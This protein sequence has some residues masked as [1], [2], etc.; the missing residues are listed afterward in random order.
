M[1]RSKPSYL[2]KAYLA[3]LSILLGGMYLSSGVYA[4]EL[5][6]TV[7][8]APYPLAPEPT[9][10]KK[11]SLETAF[12]RWSIKVVWDRQHKTEDS[13]EARLVTGDVIAGLVNRLAK[14]QRL[15]DAQAQSLYEDRRKKYY[16]DA[17]H[18]GFGDKIVFMGHIELDA[19]AYPAAQANA[20]WEFELIAED[21]KPLT[22][23]Q[24]ELGDP[25]LQKSGKG[26]ASAW[27]RAFTVTF[28]NQ[29]PIKKRRVVVAGISHLT[30]VLKGAAGEGKATYLFD[31]AAH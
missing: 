19:E 3:I 21:G 31:T 20:P 18:G 14:D 5:K 2:P 25:R 15:T 11:V 12:H 22:P 4:E 24:V 13:F 1:Q 30:L 27:Y 26:G 29:D 10:P 16:G 6:A 28:A 9:L 7:R 17:E 23:L 8:K